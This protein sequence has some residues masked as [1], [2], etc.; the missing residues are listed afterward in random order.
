MRGKW[1][2][3]CPAFREVFGTSLFWGGSMM[4]RQV[5]FATLAGWVVILITLTSIPNPSFHLSIPY[6][7]KIAHF[8]FYGV[9]GFLCTLW[10]RE[11]GGDRAGAILYAIA[12]VA[13]LGAADEIHQ[14]W[15]PGRS[16]DLLDWAADVAGGAAGALSSSAAVSLFPSLLTPGNQP[17]PRAVTD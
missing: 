17:A 1:G 11:S 12:F 8:G 13:F 14:R 5:Y 3:E 9:A 16:M 2:E 4:R 7:D 10:R 6:Q 15:I